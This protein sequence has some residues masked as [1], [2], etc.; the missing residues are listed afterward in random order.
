MLVSKVLAMK[1]AAALF[2]ANSIISCN[3]RAATTLEDASPITAEALYA[4]IVN[5][6]RSR[7]DAVL[8]RDVAALRAT[9]GREYYHIDSNGRSRSKTDFLQAI[10]RDNTGQLSYELGNVEVF[11]AGDGSTVYV[12][13]SYLGRAT[14][15]T[16]TRQTRGRF[17]RVWV[18]Q[19]D[20]WKNTLHQ[21]TQIL[22]RLP[23]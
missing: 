11:A 17:V 20:Q 18:L 9:L 10:E 22:P 1:F 7:A 2:V 14:E 15:G 5:A 4:A 21:A 23:Q 13:G 16:P 6:E 3:V 12:A 19:N 8:R